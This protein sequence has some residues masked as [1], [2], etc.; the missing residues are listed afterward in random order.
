MKK[1]KNTNQPTVVKIEKDFNVIDTYKNEIFDTRITVSGV[2][3]KAKRAN[4]SLF[5]SY[6]Q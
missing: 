6:S 2:L 1:E 3:E 4:Q 5:S